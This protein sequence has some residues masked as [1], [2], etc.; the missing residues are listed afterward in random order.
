MPIQEGTDAPALQIRLFDGR[1]DGTPT[2]IDAEIAA[3]GDVVVVTHD[4]GDLP[5]RVYGRDDHEEHLLLPAE[6]KDRLL[7]L[8]LRERFGGDLHGAAQLREFLE[9]HSLPVTTSYW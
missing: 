3:A 5:R 2:T 6:H 1:P 4:V 8:L 9:Q 7:L